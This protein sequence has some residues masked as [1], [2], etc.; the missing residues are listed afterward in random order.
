MQVSSVAWRSCLGMVG[1]WL[2]LMMSHS[3]QDLVCAQL[4][5]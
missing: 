2:T 1:S 4:L 5:P 3:I